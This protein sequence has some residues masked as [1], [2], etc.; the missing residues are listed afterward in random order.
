VGALRW[1]EPLRSWF[2][3][4][5]GGA[6][7]ALAAV[8]LAAGTAAIVGKLAVLSAGLVL[9]V[10]GAV[11]RLDVGDDGVTVWPT[12]PRVPWSEIEGFE[13]KGIVLGAIRLYR[14]DRIRPTTITIQPIGR[15]RASAVVDRLND[16]PR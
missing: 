9:L 11:L 2:A 4:V 3:I 16:E 10:P 6:L 13:V 5:L 7:V 12:G 15:R 8:A 1:R 14:I